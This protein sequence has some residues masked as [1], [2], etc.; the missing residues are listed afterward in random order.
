LLSIALVGGISVL[1]LL[2]STE[3]VSTLHINTPISSTLPTYPPTPPPPPEFIT[4]LDIY[5]ES[6]QSAI[7]RSIETES[8][9]DINTHI[10]STPPTHY[11]PPSPPPEPK[12]K[13]HIYGDSSCTKAISFIKWGQIE[14][15]GHVSRTVYIKNSGDRKITL[16]LYIENWNP[17]ESSHHMNLSWDYE[18]SSIGPGSTVEVT[19]TLTLDPSAT[20][21][22]KFSFE[23]L[24]IG[25]PS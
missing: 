8:A 11:L 24:I 2:Q 5:L 21:I 6:L 20:E 25:S 23:I 19:L 15:G 12:I 10:T 3:N 7:D 13:L 4:E 16:S 9:I 1:G 17:V 14:V 22:E 18:G